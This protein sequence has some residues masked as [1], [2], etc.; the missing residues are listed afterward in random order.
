M[1]PSRSLSASAILLL[2]APSLA[3]AAHVC[4]DPSALG[5]QSRSHCDAAKTAKET[6]KGQKAVGTVQ[7]GVAA[8]CAASCAASFTMM[9]ITEGYCNTAAVAG[10]VFTIVKAKEMT[11]K[12]MG[13][14]S[15][16]G[17]AYSV[18]NNGFGGAFDF[19]KGGGNFSA[20][21]GAQ[22]AGTKAFVEAGGKVDEAGK[23]ITNGADPK[24]LEA[25]QKAADKS[26]S[27]A[28]C[29]T[30]G[31]SAVSSFMSFEGAK[32]SEKTANQN[33]DAAS[34]LVSKINSSLS[35]GQA[36]VTAGTGA[37]PGSGQ[38]AM[39][40]GGASSVAKSTGISAKSSPCDQPGFNATVSCALAQPGNNLPSFVATPEFRNT[41]EKL[42]GISADRIAGLDNPGAMI[43]AGMG[44]VLTS[45]GQEKLGSILAETRA[46][47]AQG[48]PSSSYAS[49]GRGGSGSGGGDGGM[50][51]LNALMDKLMPKTEEQ[52]AAPTTQEIQFDSTRDLST[53]AGDE[54]NRRISI[55]ARVSTRYQI[56]RNRLTTRQYVLEGN[57]TPNERR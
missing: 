3:Q 11:D 31:L 8:V 51:D 46:G 16:G 57:Q 13:M 47:V 25:G 12:M 10:T 38:I 39:G 56:S 52:A 54:E 2:L 37:A 48:L 28:S 34:S 35:T 9:P 27:H 5:T 18:M 40:K 14:M 33:R 42:S 50:P 24:A 15:L 49:A 44:R 29:L 6:A 1:R 43:Q 30:A 32:N 22:D 36:S 26:Q 7:A 55:F 23:A 4:D 20:Q 41:L 19:G 53:Q 45:Q 21:A 17:T